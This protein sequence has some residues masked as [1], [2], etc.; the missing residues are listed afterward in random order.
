MAFGPTVAAA[1]NLRARRGHRHLLCGVSVGV[2]ALAGL[3][4]AAQDA[5]RYWDANGALPASGGNGNWDTTSPL[6]STNNSDVLGPYNAWNNAGLDNVFF[7]SAA[8]GTTAT[9][10]TITLTQPIT[11][12]N[13]TFQTLNGWVLNGGTLTLGGTTPTINATSAATINSIIA[14]T[15][16]LTK[17]GA[18]SL[19]LTGTNT[20]SGGI[21]L[22]GGALI[23]TDAALG[24]LGNTIDVTAN[25]TLRIDGAATSRTID[26]ASG[27]TLAVA[28]AGVG[29]ALF[30]GGGGLDV[31]NATR[32]TNDA[33]T[34]K[35]STI[36]RG[37]AGIANT[38]FSSVRNLGETSSLGAPTD[39]AAGTIIFQQS[40]QYSDNIIYIGDGDTSDR[41]WDF[42]GASAWLNNEGTG[43]LNLT[44]DVDI[45]SG[46]GFRAI[47]ADFDF[48]GVLSGGTYS[49]NAS[50][51]RKITVSGVANTFT[52]N[53]GIGGLVEVAS[54]ANTGTAS[55][56]GAGSSIGLNVGTLS[57]TGAAASSDRS[58]TISGASS[59][60]NDGTGALALGG[61][62]SFV[63]GGVVDTLTLGGSF[64][65]ENV[66]AGVISGAGNIVSD[67][68]GTWVLGGANAYVG[69]TTVTSGTL[70]AGNASAFGTA[71]KITV[72]GGV[73]D[74]NDFSLTTSELHGSGGSIGLGAN[75]LTTLT[76]DGA[77]AG[78]F[79]GT[80]TG[81]G[82]LTKLGTSTLT[83][84]GANTYTG[85]TTIGG[86][87]LAL[88][89]AGS[90][91]PANNI[92]AGGS[93]LNMS[94]GKL[95]VTGAAGVTNDQTFAS[96]TVSAGAN[97][98][99]AV[100][101]AGGAVNLHLGSISRS[102]GLVNFVLPSSGS[103][104]TASASL[105]GWATVNGTDYA[106]VVGGEILPF[107]EV[108]Y[109]DKDE[110][111][112]WLSGE[113]ISDSDGD[114]L[115]YSGTLTGSMQIGGLQFT[116]AAVSNVTVAAGQTLGVDGA[117]I[118]APSVANNN[119]T[120]NGGNLRGA[121]GG[122]LGVQ[123]NGGGLFT[124]G[125]TV[126]D[127]GGS[128]GLTKGGTG[129]LLL[130]GA[131]TY[132]GATTLS[133]G[134]LEITSLANGGAASSIGQS[135]SASANLVLQGGTLAWTGAADAVSN[136]GFTLVNGGAG[137]P[138]I[139]VGAARS[140]EFSGLA[141]S[142]DDA[143][144]TKTGAGT[145]VLSNTANDYVGVT[146]I[147]GVSGGGAIAVNTL[148]N[149]GQVS[150]IGKASAASTNLVLET[151]GQL[152]FTG[153][154][155]STNR[156]FTLENG[157]KIGV[158]QAA[159]T[160]TIGG[161][162][163]GS[164]NLHKE[165]AGTLVLAG[166]NTYSGPTLVNAGVL[167]AGSTQAFGGPN[168]MTLA[169][170]AGVALNLAGFNNKVGGLS[171]GGAAGGNVNLGAAT[172]T[173]GG[174]NAVFNGTID[175]AGGLRKENTSAQT[176]ANCAS[177]YTGPTSLLAGTL[178]VACLA[179]GGQVSSIG[180]SGAA[181]ANLTFGGG[182]LLYTGGTAAI[183]R[184]MLMQG[185]GVVSIDS[186]AT[187]LEISGAITG[188]GNLGKTGDGTLVLSGANNYS[189]GT[190]VYGGTLR[191][192]SPSALGTGGVRMG[193]AG[194]RLDLSAVAGS[195]ISVGWIDDSAANANAASV[196]DIDLGGTTLTLTPG[197]SA[198][199]VGGSAN[200]AGVISGTGGIVKA[201]G[202]IQQFSGCNNAYTGA[203]T[204]SGG[205]LAVDCLID[206]ASA[207]SIGA[208]SFDAASLILNGGTLRY[209]GTG[210]TTNR[211][212][213]LGASTTSALDASGTGA[214]VFSNTAPIAFGSANTAQTVT[215]TGTSTAENK[216]GLQ[217]TDNGTGKT[218]LSKTGLG[219]WI[220]TNPGS[221][222]TG[223]T[224]ITG[225]VLG[226]DK[227][228]DGGLTSSLGQ[229]SNLAS[230]L[231]IGG[232]AT[233][234]Y[235]GAG[236]TTD[237]RFTLG[238]GTTA[239][240]SS[241]TGAVVF[242]NTSAVSY[243]GNGLRVVSLGGTNADDNV[244]GAAVGNQTAANVSS[245]AK[246]G[247]GKWILTGNN[248]YTGVTNI[249]TGTLIL[250]AGGATG[251]IASQTVNNFGVLGFE[252]SDALTYGGVISQSGSVEQLG[253]GKTTLTG[254]NIYT[255]GTAI[256]AGTLELGSGGA[257]GSI[258][259]DVTN[260]GAFI[261]NRN[262]TYAF[263]GL[264][265]G[266]G[267][268]RQTGS[269]VTVL[270]AAN[271]YQGATDVLAGTLRVNGDQSAATGLTTVY[272]GA[273]LGGAGTIGGDVVVQNGGAISPGNSP[274]TLTI[275]GDLVLNTSSV[276]NMEFGQAN[277]V[278][279]A[280]N[281]LIVVNGDLTLDGVINVSVPTGGAFTAGVYRVIDY[282]GGL[283]NNTL[284]VGSMPG[285]ASATV[286]TSVAGQVNLVNSAGQTLYFWDGPTGGKNDSV[287]TGGTGTWRLGGGANEWANSAGSVNSDFAADA[288]A[289]FQ[290]AAG[291][292]TVDSAGGAVGV[293]G[294]QFAV[295]G[296]TLSGGS[297]TLAA[298]Q[299]PIRVGD[300]TP[301]GVG[302][303]ATI[304]SV[305]SGGGQ[306]VK[307][308]A[309]TLVLTATNTHT[310]G[311]LINEGVLQ[312]SQESSLGAGGLTLDGGTL[313][314]NS[315]T[316]GRG[317]TLGASGGTITPSVS[318]TVS[319]AITGIGRLTKGGTGIL[320]L[321]G[322]NTYS[323][324][325]TISGGALTLGDGGA[326]GSITGDVLNN[327]QLIFNSPGV[328]TF[329]GVISG[330]GEVRKS[331]AG[332]Q[333]LTGANTYAGATTVSAGTLLING[334]QSTASG[335]TTV[336]AGTLGGS[337]TLGGDVTV[338]AAAA[339]APGGAAGAPGTLT[340]KG[341]LA[342]ADATTSLN[343]EFGQANLPGGTFN[344]LIK[345][346]GDASLGGAT[347][348]VASSAPSFG[349][350]L[351]RVIDY[352]GTR[353][354]SLTLGAQPAG[355]SFSVQTSVDKQVNLVNTAGLN[356]NIWDGDAGGRND[357]NIAGG[358]GTWQGASGNDNWTLADGSVNAAFA[359]SSFAVFTKTGGVVTVDAAS[360]G[361]INVLG[362]QF[363]A[364]GYELTGDQINL[365]AP[366][367]T[368]WVGDGTSNSA[369]IAAVI[370]ANLGGA[371]GLVKT[372]A[373]TLHL[374]GNNFYAG[375]TKIDGG[376]LE[377]GGDQSGAT[378]ATFVNSGGVLKGNGIVG[379]DVSVGA[380][381]TLA[382]GS[383]YGQL[384]INGD[385]ILSA[386]AVLAMELG[387][388]GT[389]G[390]ALNDLIVVG[391]DL[392]LDGVLN[393]TQSVG[394]AFGPGVYRLIDYTGA[395]TDNT[396]NIGSLPSDYGTVQTSI[397]RQVNLV[398]SATPPGG[399]PGPGPGTDPGAGEPGGPP[400]SPYN[401]WDGDKGVASDST[402][403]GGDGIWRASPANWTTSTGRSNG[404]FT[405][406]SF[407][408][409]AAQAG[410][411]TVDG[412][413]GPI[414]VSGM[415][416]AADGYQLTGDPVALQAGEAIVRV[417]DGTSLGGAFSATIDSK[418][419]GAGQLHKSDAGTLILT[420]DSDYAG[421]TRVSGGALQLGDGG[422]GGSIRG[423][424]QNDSRV[425]FNR[426]DDLLFAGVI[427]GGGVIA[428]IGS[429]VTTLSGD[430]SAFGGRS[431]VRDGTLTVDGK[432]GGAVEVFD[433]GR[434]TGHGQVGSLLNQ[435][436]GVVAPGGFG[437]LTVTGGYEGRGGTLRIEAVL[438]GDDSQTDRLLVRGATS[439]S[440]LVEVANRGGLGARTSNGIL[441]VDVE[442]ASDGV[443]TLAKGDF[444]LGGENALVAGAYAY[445]LRQDAQRGD[446]KLHSSVNEVAG[447][448]RPA[449][450][451][452]PAG[453]PGPSVDGQPQVT[454][455][456]PG[457]PVYEA[458]AHTLQ[459][460]NGLSTMR[461]RVGARQWSGEEGFGVWGR[462]EGGRVKL[463][464]AV[465]TT[466]AKLETDRWKV[467]FGI[468][469]ALADDLAG[470]RLVASLTAQYGEASTA[471][472]SR[473][474]GGSLD[475]KSTGVGATLTW[476]NAQ[477][478]YVDA[479]AQANWF[480]TDLR[481][482]ILGD[483]AEDADGSGYAISLEA[484]KTMST[485]SD[486]RLT[487]QVQ[488]TYAKVDFDSFVDPLGA[489][490]AAD[491]GDSLLARLG[492]ALDRDWTVT[493]S[494]GEGRLYG[495]VNLTHEFLDG[496]Q[497]DVSGAPL[498]NRAERTWGGLAVGGS[499]G[500]G[501]GRYLVYVEAAADTPIS[502]F[503]D[504]YAVSGTAGFSMRF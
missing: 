222:Y 103:I 153:G 486:L 274:G 165:G 114:G 403:S 237:R 399:G 195:A 322:V 452:Q 236:D 240:E 421:G 18:G 44:G 161:A 85:A 89:F 225:G 501:A 481:S 6:W 210:H 392:T 365:T 59:L 122:V 436:G 428:Q 204:I 186:A 307:V 126:V 217:L 95:Q 323:G 341:D 333:M 25:S 21:T 300:L 491:D 45:S 56:L 369:T 418:L 71:G 203:T 146:R 206:G 382:P 134:R 441:V 53:A 175:G 348:N 238:V 438:G 12:H 102:S 346:G 389:P 117:I 180:A 331:G 163:V 185:N 410:T 125:S 279:G 412:S 90:G 54:L 179:N 472:G 133:A 319:G 343:Y 31:G 318:T 128:T 39:A 234:R 408:V 2:L 372:D 261:F 27:R 299:T 321:T 390:G 221:T 477:G 42:N 415:Q 36:F 315:G 92:I 264:V 278:G 15:A 292:V 137:D 329:E 387:Q 51:G 193:L 162:A 107:A 437:V 400:A 212:F 119:Q 218:G 492:V 78:D 200:Y 192:L 189:G 106:K 159:T 483:R 183:D 417:G 351:Y 442:G 154:T 260:N 41:N 397:A 74:L 108:D 283:T 419:T 363:A 16:G 330:G 28:G 482:S 361:P 118:I 123:Q 376:T 460:L 62:L 303:T 155:A 475:A 256:R 297:L 404:A 298:G 302:M 143:G 498:A 38:Y 354:G 294:I 367:S 94:G 79:A 168:L 213:T 370:N 484:G 286:Q 411:V 280:L 130:T 385:L 86:G 166:V 88:N 467:Q 35:G 164:G 439:G 249:N 187:T 20:F 352:T 497:V 250:G 349:P 422:K 336:S 272:S 301:A 140:V 30:N 342:L 46:G 135:S 327:A 220:L 26:I 295:D 205:V 347:I 23:A 444:R 276:L 381:G 209:V 366:Q 406:A 75:P 17:I 469:Q 314:I 328:Q 207:S 253:A 393:V 100:S 305:L 211:L 99:S 371:G 66:H 172:L 269:G 434:L 340:I 414:R 431:E 82:G 364:T 433:G 55:S 494:G 127:N 425:A 499:Y 401:F 464:P 104:T 374:F 230:N 70:R 476:T 233:L 64:A 80:I 246:N 257:T 488:L 113:F 171:G 429:G 101:G 50:A 282:T 197:G 304:N 97:T 446:W 463:D 465:S 407:A 160:L 325:T 427:S 29:S 296:Y 69:A 500:W 293:S 11:V 228:A 131:N 312:I 290:G 270:S 489:R 87:T 317:I 358:A 244:M 223:V 194:T 373:G 379:G 116:E 110:V 232:G 457:A 450:P 4:A 5:A 196:G 284:S 83:L 281:D 72:N 141:T 57:Y 48:S 454:L 423:D 289:V 445:V 375:E 229:S 147:T 502:G 259:G 58:W 416:F 157:G 214:I 453:E 468:D 142:S 380:G 96:T 471:V 480:E 67:G 178:S 124:I 136:R 227:L 14:G 485:G 151:G 396:L 132:T 219:A 144:L 199:G 258:M 263:N 273:T 262:N 359:D 306:L 311:T 129:R 188:V 241:G 120:I 449:D 216:L 111:A 52:G 424:V 174:T 68:A 251:S 478:A 493:S 37:I 3:P 339:L 243:N 184:G 145:L 32:L 350:G 231:V 398:V 121:A 455:Y 22:S 313:R 34:Y 368:I 474:G 73:L 33:N 98:I 112:T 409:F 198:L 208:S 378:G 386:D 377:I 176:L 215:L 201:G 405:P 202:S 285:G 252:R 426:A 167:R 91:A 226:V 268:L 308:D 291:T 356:L 495:L 353:T 266:S 388:V 40:S 109:T 49:F 9:V 456:Q 13:I 338:A 326:A 24:A 61:G 173:I 255:G 335:L 1:Q 235:T 156:G 448:P 459:A 190:N 93:A 362:M 288:F 150:G 360:G 169:D 105:G 310:G 275:N 191:V 332:T 81:A 394:G 435:A 271:S 47:G 43:A 466:Q 503:G 420:G 334:D 355:A 77:L 432:L 383:A 19:T 248:T 138:K 10:G 309:G 473:F 254:T 177:T 149:G 440:T 345:V 391:G 504:S 479:Q 337:G 267:R 182:T 170:A 247:A 470:G 76:V 402:V 316:L 487:P 496:S 451:D 320:R 413:E 224:S 490:V 430:S 63:T 8:A 447:P 395:L 265:S 461:Q 287:I 458:Y 65:G 242:G 357:T 277:A 245:L 324:G 384:T 115:G 60:L 7:G 148:T 152:L 239:I 84:T 443:F 158:S 181:S 139:E 462:T 344:D